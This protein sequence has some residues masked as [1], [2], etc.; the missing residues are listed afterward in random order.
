MPL[1]LSLALFDQ[2]RTNLD[3]VGTSYFHNKYQ[4]SGYDKQT[5]WWW[6]QNRILAYSVTKFLWPTLR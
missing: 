5:T 3:L 4:Y 1:S 2:N 6:K